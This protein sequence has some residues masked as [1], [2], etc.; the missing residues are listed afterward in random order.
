VEAGVLGR[1]IHDPCVESVRRAA[2]IIARERWSLAVVG[3][4]GA[5]ERENLERYFAAGASAVMMGS[6]PMYLPDLAAGAKRSHPE[7]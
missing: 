2:A 5:A 4:G 3:V 7:W 1:T 6:S